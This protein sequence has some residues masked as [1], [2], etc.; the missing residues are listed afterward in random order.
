MLRDLGQPSH[1][2]ILAIIVL[3]LFGYKKLPDMTRSVG[4]SLRIF[5]TELKG[6]TDDDDAREGEATK[7]ETAAAP[8]TPPASPV[9][10][11]APPVTPLLQTTVVEP[12]PAEPVSV[13]PVSVPPTSAQAPE[14]QVQQAPHHTSNG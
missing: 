5:K 8:A 14:A 11:P 3:V 9:T 2:L 13:D 6:M 12:P 10:P 1:L 7:G 4:R